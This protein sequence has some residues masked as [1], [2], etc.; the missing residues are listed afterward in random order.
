MRRSPQ[1]RIISR[2]VSDLHYSAFP[3]H[4]DKRI[5]SSLSSLAE[6]GLSEKSCRLLNV[7]IA[8]SPEDT[9]REDTGIAIFD[10]RSIIPGARRFDRTHR[11]FSP[12]FGVIAAS[13]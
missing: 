5:G 13:H 7:C 6:T 2:Q 9:A 3:R 11:S 4:I 12:S 10:P 8:S 1:L